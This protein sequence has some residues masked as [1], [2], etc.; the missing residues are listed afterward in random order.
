MIYEYI[1]TLFKVIVGVITNE[2]LAIAA[3]ISFGVLLLWVIFSLC[4]SFQM[5]FMTG[6][7]KINEY[8]SR[9]GIDG[10]NRKS[11]VPY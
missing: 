10:E 2:R 11:P 3:L 9:H 7:R 5:R 1:V 4:F 6:A 8:I